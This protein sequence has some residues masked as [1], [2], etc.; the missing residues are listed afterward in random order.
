MVSLPIFII[1]IG[2]L[3]SISN[4][5]TVPWNIEPTGQ[6]MATLT[7]DTEV[8]FDNPS[9]ETLPAK[10]TYEVTERYITLNMTGDGNLTKESGAR[11]KANADGVQAIKVLIREPQNASGKRPGV[12]FM[13]GAGYGTC[14]N[15]FGDVASGMASAGFVTAV[16]DKPVWNT[17]DINRDYPASAKAYDQVIEY[18]RDQSDVD[19]AKVGIY[20]TSES[21]WISSY[22][23]E[24]DPD[25]AFQIL[26][27]PM[28][29]SPANRWD[30]SSPKTSP[31]LARTKAIN[32]SSNVCSA[33]TPACSD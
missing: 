31:L 6:S 17:T 8:T 22:L 14:D 7:D 12:V 10:G 16:L 30:F 19:E 32:P 23:L 25:I 26:L 13:H 5:T 4:L 9:G 24:D 11:G 18:L 3:V 33:R 1:L 29:F 28:V 21:T 27:S 20:A 2:V 15:S